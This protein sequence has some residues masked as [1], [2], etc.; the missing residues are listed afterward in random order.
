MKKTTFTWFAVLLALLVQVATAQSWKSNGPLPRVYHS[1]VLDPST[2]RM[3]VFGGYSPNTA[4]GLDLNDVWRLNPSVSLAGLQNWI[5]VNPAGTPPSG[6]LGTP[7]VYDGGSNRMVLFGGSTDTGCANDIWALTNANGSS[8]SAW[9]QLTVL[10][11][12]PS[13]RA[14]PGNAYDAQSHTLMV[15]GGN[16]CALGVLSDY[17]ILTH[18]DGVSGT[19]AWVQLSPLGG[20]PGP[21]TQ[22]SA[23]YDPTTNVFILFGGSDDQGVFYNDVWVLTNANGTG[24]TPTWTQ[25]SP[26]GNPPTARHN[27][28]A[29]YDPST[30]RLT[31]F[32]G[33]NI[34]TSTIF[35]DTWVLTNANGTG[36]MPSWT[37]I[38]Q[39]S[40]DFPAARF[41][42]TAVYD[43]GTNTMTVF[44]GRVDLSINLATSDVFLLDRANGQSWANGKTSN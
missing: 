19:P 44:G 8:P 21:R 10:G 17:W 1:A 35:G 11:N 15:Y 38:A 43:S 39:S 6:R 33:N 12:P 22:V 29:T 16:G 9:V 18:A 34:N 7:A 42:H 24:G 28:S 23:V 37:Q 41:G 20:G 32:G 4:S 40:A 30:N 25:L 27:N 26:G 36:G 13:A 31:I 5:A 3:I 2:K 14:W